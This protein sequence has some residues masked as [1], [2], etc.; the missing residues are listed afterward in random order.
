MGHFRY[1]K[2]SPSFTMHRRDAQI[3]TVMAT[4]GEATESGC[5]SEIQSWAWRAATV[6]GLGSN[7]GGLNQQ[8]CRSKQ[9]RW[10]P[11][12]GFKLLESHKMKELFFENKKRRNAWY[13]RPNP[14]WK[15]PRLPLEVVG[16]S[17]SHLP[18][19]GRLG[20]HKRGAT[21]TE[22]G[23]GAKWMVVRWSSECWV[24]LPGERLANG[25]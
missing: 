16:L 20:C 22:S 10:G 24:N 14:F 5:P 7:F 6:S 15:Y 12:Y 1:V 21:G 18:H 25:I 3:H 13:F 19:L 8:K 23:V 2:L 4:D 17:E 11:N 9:E